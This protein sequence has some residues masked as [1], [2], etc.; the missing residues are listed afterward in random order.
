[1][2]LLHGATVLAVAGALVLSVSSPSG[3]VEAAEAR[4]RGA[5]STWTEANKTG[6]G[7]ARARRSNVWFTLQ[8]GRMSEVFYPDLSTPSVR[9]LEFV[10][11]DGETFT[12]RTSRHT[13]TTVDRPDPRSLRFTQTN[14]DKDGRYRL[15]EQYVT[16]SDHDSVVVRVRL[17]SL[18]GGS[19]RLYVLH[20]PALTN[21]GMDDR[22]GKRPKGLL[23]ADGDVASFLVSEPR[24]GARANGLVGT[25]TDPWRDLRRDH[26]LD[27]RRDRAG[28]GNVV[29]LGRVTGVTGLEG[30]RQGTLYLGLGRTAASAQQ[31]AKGARRTGWTG[32][33]QRYD[34]GWHRYLDGLR[35]VPSSA[36]GVTDQYLASALVLAAAEDKL[37]RGA[38]VAS[39]SA[40]W[41]WGDELEDLASPSGAYHLVWS[42]DSYE[43]G[44][45]LWAMGDRAAARRSVDWL[46]GVQ[47]RRDGSFPQNSDVR[48]R[49]VWS[50]LQ[51]DEVALPVVLA[52][53]VGKDDDRTWRGVRRAVG[54]LLG[55][56]DEETGRRAPYSP[57]ERWENQSGYS[58]NSI[59]AQISALVV[60]ADMARDRGRKALAR[61]WLDRADRWASRVEK[62]TVTTNG[63]LSTEPYFLRLTK[64]GKPNTASPYAMGDGGP[65]SIDQRAVV[66]PS[67]LDLVRYGITAPDDLEVLTTLPVIDGELGFTT[68]NGRFWHRFSHDGY[69]ETRDGGQWEITDPGTDTTLGRGWPLLTGERGEYAVAAGEDGTPYL[70]A[71][72]AA[73]GPSDMISEQVWD[74]RP[75][76]GEPCC[77]LGEGTRA[78]T[79][80]VWSHAGL[81]RLAWTIERGTPVDQQSVV[82]DR[83]TR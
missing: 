43:F 17:T 83:Y 60:A 48:G 36:A 10:V 38:I 51:L 54:F 78:A 73:S 82:A 53:L 81:V 22:A 58:P 67:F 1:M 77:P 31:H 66:D 12:D 19:Y 71:M 50:E 14:T 24:L 59:A 8:D 62:W 68:P 46:F 57:Q 30:A 29:Q 9:S 61:R 44:T 34:D 26:D 3:T 16:S 63:P 56:R 20:D 21:D 41:A 23:A 37:N 64:N 74:G 80:L 28:P 7:T 5:K 11:T 13:D 33:R 70:A 39:P 52:G 32:T 49:P 40:P 47:Q 27:R 18:D 79:P 75:P 4:E 65:E 76:T 45:A 72:A 35:P 42:R 2:R 6:F 69:G 25:G 15:T 55:F